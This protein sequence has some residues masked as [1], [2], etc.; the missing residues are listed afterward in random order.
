MIAISPEKM[1]TFEKIAVMETLWA[2]LC[3]HSSLES[4][5]WHQDVLS[6]RAQQR[7]EGNQQPIDWG[8][9]K[10]QLRDSLS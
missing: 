5:E 4:P 6:S 8:N 10:Q 1:T 3:Q 9:A 7:L 2:D